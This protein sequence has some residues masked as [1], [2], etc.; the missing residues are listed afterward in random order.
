MLN[1]DSKNVLSYIFHRKC[2]LEGALLALEQ[3]QSGRKVTLVSTLFQFELSPL[4]AK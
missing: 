2:P 4:G 1:L 3:H